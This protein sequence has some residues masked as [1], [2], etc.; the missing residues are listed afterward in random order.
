MVAIESR[1]FRDSPFSATVRSVASPGGAE[2]LPAVVETA[3]PSGGVVRLPP[4]AFRTGDRFVLSV[5]AA[6]HN[7][8]DVVA[9]VVRL[10][11]SAEG[12]CRA[13]VEFRPELPKRQ[14]VLMRRVADR[15]TGG[16]H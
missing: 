11:P 15:P 10:E 2:P 16:A 7:L 14:F 1:S 8:L 6:Q 13:G 5:R 12:G 3:S 9:E 4:N